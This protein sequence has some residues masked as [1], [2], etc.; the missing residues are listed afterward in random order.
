MPAWLGSGEAL[1]LVVTS[2]AERQPPSSPA[3]FYKGT[4]PIVG[5]H[6]HGLITSEHHHAGIRASTYEFSGD[7]NI[8]STAY[9]EF[10]KCWLRIFTP[11]KNTSFPN[12]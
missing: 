7:I 11:L 6:P 9:P 5:L 4:N 3:S 10:E 2:D 12:F 1:I 8:Q